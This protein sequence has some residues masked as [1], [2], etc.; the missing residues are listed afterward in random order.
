MRYYIKES[1]LT[2]LKKYVNKNF[3]NAVNSGWKIAEF[4]SRTLF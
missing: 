1:K 3:I 4:I 2:I